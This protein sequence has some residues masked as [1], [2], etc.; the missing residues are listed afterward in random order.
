LTTAVI[1]GLTAL[2]G[3]IAYVYFRQVSVVPKRTIKSVQ[4]D[5]EWA[6]S[7]LNLNAS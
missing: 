5:V 4:E 2:T 1:L 6:R 7:Q 3:L